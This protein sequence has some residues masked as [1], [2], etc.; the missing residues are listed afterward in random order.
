MSMLSYALEFR[1]IPHWQTAG[2]LAAVWR[3]QP[4]L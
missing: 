4:F 1:P 3:L 2:F